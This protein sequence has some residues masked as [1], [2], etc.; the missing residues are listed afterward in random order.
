VLGVVL[1]REQEQGP[2]PFE[3]GTER[4]RLALQV[5]LGLGVRGVGE[6]VRQLQQG[7]GARLQRPPQADL[8]AQALRLPEGLLRAALVVP[9]PGL[10]GTGIQGGEAGFLGG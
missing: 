3:L 8:L 10:A 2:L 4:I 1:A 9:E 7:S 5:S 6:Q